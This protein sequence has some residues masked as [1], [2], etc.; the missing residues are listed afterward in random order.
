MATGSPKCQRYGSA[1]KTMNGS[2]LKLPFALT[3]DAD[4]VRSVTSWSEQLREN[5]GTNRGSGT[6]VGTQ[7]VPSVE[8]SLRA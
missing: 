4:D 3:R 2:P 1:Y 8:T 7:I 6:G 5:Q